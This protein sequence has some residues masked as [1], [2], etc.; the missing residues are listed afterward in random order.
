MRDE[1]TEEFLQI[2]DEDDEDD[3]ED[4]E[5]GGRESAARSLA[6]IFESDDEL[7]EVDAEQTDESL[8]VSRS[9]QHLR[10]QAACTS[11]WSC[12]TTRW[13]QLLQFTGC[14]ITVAVPADS[15]C[16]LSAP[17]QQGLRSPVLQLVNCGL[18][19]ETIGALG[20]KG[21]TS[22][23]PIQKHVYD[24]AASGRDM[25][26]RAKTGS[27]KTLAFALPV[28]EKLIAVCPPCFTVVWH[29]VPPCAGMAFGR[30]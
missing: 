8:L 17:S 16:I 26:G 6:S 20:E 19:P 9:H 30:G 18:S 10:A 3:L 1:A 13:G 14:S 7:I 2:E 29:S 15:P 22:L 24:P 4:G 5:D 21:I 28:I 25:I 12:K 11:F 27:G 23:F